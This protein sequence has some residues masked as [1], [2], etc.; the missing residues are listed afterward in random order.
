[1]GEY[2]L[3]ITGPRALRMLHLTKSQFRS[4]KCEGMPPRAQGSVRDSM[5]NELRTPLFEWPIQI[6]LPFFVRAHHIG[7]FLPRTHRAQALE[8]MEGNGGRDNSRVDKPCVRGDVVTMVLAHT[9]LQGKVAIRFSWNLAR[10]PYTAGCWLLPFP[11]HIEYILLP[12]IAAQYAYAV[13]VT[14]MKV[15]VIQGESLDEVPHSLCLADWPIGTPFLVR[16]CPSESLRLALPRGSKSLCICNPTDFPG[17]ALYVE[18]SLGLP[19]TLL[20]V[21]VVQAMRDRSGYRECRSFLLT[22]TVGPIP[23]QTRLLGECF[24]DQTNILMALP[25][26]TP[27]DVVTEFF[28]PPE[29]GIGNREPERTPGFKAC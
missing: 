29:P 27:E 15:L 6:E 28:F 5:V 26:A 7:R 19:L 16:S 12:H 2:F 22:A 10:A 18:P 25:C 9:A 1:M 8:G 21:M 20:Q 13:R 14:S 23:S 4:T 24:A 3:S 17:R 11:A